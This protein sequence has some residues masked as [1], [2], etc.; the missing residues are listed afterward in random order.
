LANRPSDHAAV[1]AV[2]I[3]RQPVV[4][5]V[6]GVEVPLCH[7]QA[8][9]EQVEPAAAVGEVVH[10]GGQ[11]DGELVVVQ[12]GLEPGRVQVLEVTSR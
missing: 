9:A 6:T 7:G 12:G 8:P 1:A 2:A 11:A 4:G 5:R 3:A 10:V